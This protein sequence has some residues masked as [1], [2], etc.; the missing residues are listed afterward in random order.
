M[1]NVDHRPTYRFLRPWI[2]TPLLAML[3]L[4]TLMAVS[5]CATAPKATGVI[6]GLHRA[7]PLDDPESASV[8]QTLIE[9]SQPVE[10]AEAEPAELSLSQQILA[11]AY[12]K[13]GL[14]YR[15]GGNSPKTG[16]DCTGFIKWVF[17]QH[18]IDLP[19]TTG[20]LAN[21]GHRVDKDEL[22][23]GDLL[24]F[25]RN[26][27]SR[28]MHAGIYVGDGQFIH[29]PHTGA[30]ITEDEAF[31]NYRSSIFLQARR[32][33]NAPNPEP[34]PEE[35]KHQIVARALSENRGTSS[36][37][38]YTAKGSHKS[39]QVKKGDTVWALARRFGVPYRSILQ[40]NGL[41]A[42]SKLKIGQRLAIP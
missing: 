17:E 32:V 6:S 8:G 41:Q 34:L 24:F 10:Q 16:F 42:S 23:P 3:T 14:P 9:K 37:A 27:G 31:D 1:T 5:G 2:G 7:G 12:G 21:V 36:P 18:G 22:L 39:Y 26:R 19:R 4:A 11:T 15:Y 29:S 40:A 38:T 33:L 25:R 30:R 13:V 20:S 35:I 28:L